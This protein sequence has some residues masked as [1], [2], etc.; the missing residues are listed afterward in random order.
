MYMANVIKTLMT[1]QPFLNNKFLDTRVPDSTPTSKP[2][3][4]ETL[5]TYNH[6]YPL[7][8]NEQDVLSTHKVSTAGLL[9]PHI[10]SSHHQLVKLFVCLL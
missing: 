9:E 7:P 6:P 10:N 4:C 1:V 8:K 3:P 5:I 2:E